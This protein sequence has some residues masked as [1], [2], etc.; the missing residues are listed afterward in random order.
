MSSKLNITRIF[1]LLILFIKIISYLEEGNEDKELGENDIRKI[2]M[3]YGQD[4]K[5]YFKYTNVSY[6]ITILSCT[7][8]AKID[9]VNISSSTG[10]VSGK[11]I[12]NQIYTVELKDKDLSEPQEGYISFNVSNINDNDVDVEIT[13]VRQN[14]ATEYKKIDYQLDQEIKVDKNNFVIFLDDEEVEKFD[15]KFS[16][17]NDIN[18]EVCYG[19]IRLPFNDEKYLPMGKSF[20][21]LKCENFSGSSKQLS[22]ENKVKDSSN[23][24][25]NYIAF[26]FSINSNNGEIKEYSFTINSEII[27]V[28]LIVSIVIAL[29]FAVITFFLIRR[30]QSSESSSI[31][32][33]ENSYNKKEEKEEKEEK[34]DKEEATEN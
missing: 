27:N 6:Y 28:F 7:P 30:K 23:G 16:F 15:M 11:R 33:E 19:F 24:L 26:I 9:F 34:G 5:L 22:V 32:G 3:T 14:S 17:N 20:K 12:D 25:K 1:L 8:G 4:E 29:I 10:N 31:E 18:N 2:N 13:S 21:Q